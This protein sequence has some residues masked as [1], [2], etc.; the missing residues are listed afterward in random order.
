MACELRLVGTCKPA[1]SGPQFRDWF[2]VNFV[3]NA[4][5]CRR[6]REAYQRMACSSGLV[7]MRLAPATASRPAAS[8]QSDAE[9]RINPNSSRTATKENAAYPQFSERR[10][11]CANFSRAKPVA[12]PPARGAPCRVAACFF[13]LLSRYSRDGPED[14][15]LTLQLAL[16]SFESRVVGANPSC[17]VDTFVHTWSSSAQ[18]DAELRERLKPRAAHFG[19]PL[20][21]G[22]NLSRTGT[23]GWPG[24][25]SP[26]ALASID[27]V[28]ELKREAEA[29]DGRLYTWV[30]LTRLD[31]I[32][33]VP[34][35]FGLLHPDLLYLANYCALETSEGRCRALQP[36][37][38]DAPDYYFAGASALVDHAFVNLTRDL[39][40]YCFF[41]THNMAG[42]HK[43]L[44]GRIESL[45]LW[46]HGIGRYLYHAF[47]VALIREYFVDHML[48]CA[49]DSGG[50]RE[51][52]EEEQEPLQGTSMASV[53]VRS[54]EEPSRWR[55][56]T[57][58]RSLCSS[59]GC[60]R[61]LSLAWRSSDSAGHERAQRDDA[62]HEIQSPA[63]NHASRCPSSLRFCG[64]S[65]MQ[66]AEAS[67]Y[68]PTPTHANAELKGYRE[69][70]YRAL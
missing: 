55:W 19:S 40:H 21:L 59:G 2:V 22:S 47:D 45:G 27:R 28:L 13:G 7:E 49:I 64:C 62:V 18:Q 6:R 25:G 37:N 53:L 63:A 46:R 31:I 17:S 48:A 34:F 68:Y 38:T 33:L 35:G 69:G 44:S 10:M 61:N 20:P 5:D 65:R 54:S 9:T 14:A 42:N 41:A 15:W 50:W 36:S 67:R 32:W 56:S 51:A 4:A 52:S 3:S 70:T 43:V 29:Q 60:G 30:L 16:P 8:K 66:M 39:E 58:Y 26:G 11:Q 12:P 23:Y 57:S 24:G 1:Y